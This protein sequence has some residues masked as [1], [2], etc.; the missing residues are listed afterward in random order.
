M[1]TVIVELQRRPAPVSAALA[2]VE[3]I[4]FIADVEVLGEG[5]RCNCAASDDN[6]Y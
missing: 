1:T 4:T 6:P 5:N 2:P 3:E